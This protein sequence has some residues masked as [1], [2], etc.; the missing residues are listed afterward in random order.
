MT[1]YY[2]DGSFVTKRA[3]DNL[4]KEENWDRTVREILEESFSSYEIKKLSRYIYGPRFLLSTLFG[5]LVPKY[6]DGEYY[7]EDGDI[8]KMFEKRFHVI[9]KEQK[10][11]CVRCIRNA[12][13]H[14]N[15]E[16]LEESN[17]IFFYDRNPK[18]K[19]EPPHFKAKISTTNLRNLIDE[20]DAY[21]RE[22]IKEAKD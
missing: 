20:L 4:L 19:H 18:K 2:T 10:R 11:T 12:L 22:K 8:N 16:I 17:E 6:Q 13:S 1:Q 7:S 21:E 15:M 9:E 3:L 14:L 5:V